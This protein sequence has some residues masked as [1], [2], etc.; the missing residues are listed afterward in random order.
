M[1]VGLTDVMKMMSQMEKLRDIPAWLINKQGV[2]AMARQLDFNLQEHHIDQLLSIAKK[3]RDDDRA[4]ADMIEADGILEK[5][6]EILTD[7][8]QLTLTCHHCGHSGPPPSTYIESVRC[9]ACSTR[10][11]TGM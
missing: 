9:P 3:V 5:V 10:L 7:A 8:T 4:V 6:S 1:A 2:V 11:P